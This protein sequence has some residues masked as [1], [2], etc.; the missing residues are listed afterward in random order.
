MKATTTA[1][2]SLLTVTSAAAEL[3]ALKTSKGGE[4][5][6]GE[7]MMMQKQYLHVSIEWDTT[8]R[9]ELENASYGI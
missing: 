7:M 9:T 3:R 6:G 1:L 2:A 8:D 5:K 4:G